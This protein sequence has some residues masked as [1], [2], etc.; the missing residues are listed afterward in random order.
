M[1]K[2]RIRYYPLRIDLMRFGIH[3]IRNG[4]LELFDPIPISTVKKLARYS[5]PALEERS[6]WQGVLNRLQR[7]EADNKPPYDFNNFSYDLTDPQ[8]YTWLPGTSQPRWMV[9]FS[10]TNFKRPQ[11]TIFMQG[12]ECSENQITSGELLALYGLANSTIEEHPSIAVLVLSIYRTKARIITAVF[13]RDHLHNIFKLGGHN[14]DEFDLPEVH[15]TEFFD[16]MEKDGY[17]RAARVLLTT[18]KFP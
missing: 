13:Y 6:G 1:P 18:T 14:K 4:V 2:S 9:N 16:L 7:A 11:V 3:G 5:D 17:Y 15:S 8:C 12:Q 10:N